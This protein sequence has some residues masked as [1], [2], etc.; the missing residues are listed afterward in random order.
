MDKPALFDCVETIEDML[1]LM[2]ELFKGIK[3]NKASIA[4]AVDSQYFYSVDIL[5]YLVKKDV[6]YRDAHDAV[7][8]MVKKCLDKN[9]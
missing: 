6:S 1:P 4:K 8:T 3:V 7:G 9:I 2:A 5:E